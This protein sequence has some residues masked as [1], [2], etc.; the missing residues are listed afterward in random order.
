MGLDQYA[1]AVKKGKIEGEVDFRFK[2]YD[3][4][5]NLVKVNV[6]DE[7]FEEIAYWRK[8]PDLQGWMRNLYNKRGGESNEF[9]CNKLLLN[10]GDLNKLEKAVIKGKLPKTTGFFFGTGNTEFYVDTDLEFIA[11]A[12]KYI[13]EGYDIVYD[14]YW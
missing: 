11:K 12:R 1:Y 10:E 2:E 5:Y 3:D 7:D 8:H 4:E 6:E 14:S 13:S 9:N